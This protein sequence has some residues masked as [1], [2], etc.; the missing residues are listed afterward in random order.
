VGSFDGTIDFGDGAH[1]TL[2]SYDA[3]VALFEP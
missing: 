1:T 3:F 2:G